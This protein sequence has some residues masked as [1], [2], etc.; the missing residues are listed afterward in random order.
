[1]NFIIKPSVRISILHIIIVLA[2]F[3]LI[4][5]KSTLNLDSKLLL[6]ANFF[7]YILT[8]ISIAVQKKQLNNENPN[9]YVRAVIGSMMIRMFATIIAVLIYV[10]LV[11][12]KYDAASLFIGL[13]L[14]LV[15]LALEVK[16]MMKLNQKNA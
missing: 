14:Y 10:K 6:V 5:L 2:I 11:E 1:M 13:S 4:P 9:V 3:L 8:L 15:Y 16:T 7:F 12:N